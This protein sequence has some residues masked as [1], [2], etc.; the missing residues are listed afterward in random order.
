M[1]HALAVNMRSIIILLCVITQLLSA[2]QSTEEKII[3]YPLD[4]C[5]VT[6]QDLYAVHGPITVIHKNREIKL[7]TKTCVMLF[8]DNPEEYISRL[9]TIPDAKAV[10]KNVKEEPVTES[11]GELET[12]QEEPPLVLIIASSLIACI[13]IWFVRTRN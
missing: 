4:T 10:E 3:P 7:C 2:E 13:I 8:E 1:S 5:P 11:I 6:E 12:T 9:P